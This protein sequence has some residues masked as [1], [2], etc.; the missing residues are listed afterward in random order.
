M[1]SVLVFEEMVQ[2]SDC[3]SP[4]G[5]KSSDEFLNWNNF[6]IAHIKEA[7]ETRCAKCTQA[8]QQGSRRV[9]EHLIN[10]EPDYWQKLADKYDPQRKF[11]KQYEQEL[12][13]VKH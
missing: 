13:T 9:I 6:L 10:H 5:T 4:V 2:R 7:L 8:Q 11:T 3:N 12:R 1:S